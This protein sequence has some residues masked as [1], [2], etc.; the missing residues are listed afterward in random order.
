MGEWPPPTSDPPSGDPEN[1]PVLAL[2]LTGTV[3]AP[4]PNPLSLRGAEGM[5]GKFAKPFEAELF[6]PL[7]SAGNN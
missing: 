2:E 5:Y 7:H 6:P 1:C 4:P 3:I